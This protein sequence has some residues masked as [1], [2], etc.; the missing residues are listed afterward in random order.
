MEVLRLAA[1]GLSYRQIGQSVGIS[2]S[3]IHQRV[4]GI[5][6]CVT[7]DSQHPTSEYAVL[8]VASSLFK[9]ARLIATTLVDSAA[10]ACANA[11]LTRSHSAWPPVC[12]KRQSST[13]AQNAMLVSLVS[14]AVTIA[15][16][17]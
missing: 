16:S 6:R 9:A 8:A 11:R 10:F 5:P 13:N 4:G 3:T 14:S 17:L 7:I 15:A 1:Q 2:A 12:P